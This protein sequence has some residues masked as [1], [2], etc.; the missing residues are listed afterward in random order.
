MH[1]NVKC[2]NLSVVVQTLKKLKNKKLMKMFI[3]VV[4]VSNFKQEKHHKEF[5]PR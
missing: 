4:I 3:D 5:F 2:L 1:E